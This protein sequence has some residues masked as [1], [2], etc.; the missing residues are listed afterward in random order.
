MRI[1]GIRGISPRKYHPVTTVRGEDPVPVPDLVHRQFDQGA[2]NVVWV[3]DI[4]YL[5]YG[6]KWAYL[7]SVR[8]G[9]SR[10]VLGRSVGTHMRAGLVED[11][12]RQ[13]VALRGTLPDEV[14]FHA[15]RGRQFTSRQL[16]DLA[17]QLPI[18]RSMGRTG[19]CWDNA[20]IETLC[21]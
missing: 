5:A 15:D 11:A 13:A 6:N 7:C 18:L 10:K 1:A 12:L 21:A 4:T 19:V 16:A 8:D 9:N 3:S 2:P 20:Q 14:V 17:T